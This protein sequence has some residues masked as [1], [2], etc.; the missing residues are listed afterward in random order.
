MGTI[1]KRGKNSWRIGTQ[2][3][4]ENGWEWVRDT[5]HL[6]GTMSEA[7]QRKEAEK[8]L[9]RLIVDVE[10]GRAKPTSAK[11]YTVAAFAEYWME[12]HVKPNL[13]A[14]TYKNYRHFLDARILPMLGNVPL[15]KLTPTMLTEWVNQVRES[16][17]RTTALPDEKLAHPRR[18]SEEARRAKA[19]P[20]DAPLS[21]RTVRHYYD[22]MDA[23]LDK[24]VQW[25]I[26]R[27]NPMEK[28]DRPAA[29]KARVH[30][31][32]EERAVELLRCPMEIDGYV[33]SPAEVVILELKG[34]E[35]LLAI[36]IHEGRNRQVRK[37]CEAAG[38]K[39][40]RLMPSTTQ[41]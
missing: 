28:V 25:D 12:Q 8:A 30:Y 38:L 7:K 6:P 21:P 40:T 41:K 5:I 22:T 3:Q 15:K 16:P 26:L 17:R 2:V 35:A 14:N 4:T 27:K 34:E 31:L 32:T 1:E 13:A 19:K 39:V 37:M 9:A 24:A 29:K 11:S 18:P 23:M 10:K 36:T 33:T 20:K